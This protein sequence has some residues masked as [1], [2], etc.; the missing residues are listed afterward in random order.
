LGEE[1]VLRANAFLRVG[2]VALGL[3][4]VGTACAG[5]GFEAEADGM[6]ASRDDALWSGSGGYIDHG[7]RVTVCFYEGREAGTPSTEQGALSRDYSIVQNQSNEFGFLAWELFFILQDELGAATGQR[8]VL[9]R[10]CSPTPSNSSDLSIILFFD[11]EGRSV[12]WASHRDRVLINVLD[13]QRYSPE[14]VIVHEVLHAYGFSHEH[15]HSYGLPEDV[16]GTSCKGNVA[17]PA[18]GPKK[19]KF[20]SLY[21]VEYDPYSI[22]NYCKESF[23]RGPTGGL[24]PGGGFDYSRLNHL[25]FWDVAVLRHQASYSGRQPGRPFTYIS[26][27]RGHTTYRFL[28]DEIAEHEVSRQEVRRWPSGVVEAPLSELSVS[29][30]AGADVTID[31]FARDVDAN[32]WLAIVTVTDQSGAQVH[33]QMFLP[34]SAPLPPEYP[35]DSWQ[36]QA[37]MAMEVAVPA[38]LVGDEYTVTFTTVDTDLTVVDETLT[39]SW[40]TPPVTTVTA[41]STERGFDGLTFYLGDVAQ[42]DTDITWGD[43]PSILDPR[44]VPVFG[45]TSCDALYNGEFH[46]ANSWIALSGTRSPGR[47]GRGPRIGL[48]GDFEPMQVGT[49][50]LRI[51][52]YV[53]TTGWIRTVKTIDVRSPVPWGRLSSPALDL[54]I[55]AKA[56]AGF[57]FWHLDPADEPVDFRIVELGVDPASTR[58]AFALQAISTFPNDPP[59]EDFVFNS[60]VGTSDTIQAGFASAPDGASGA[61]FAI[62][63]CTDPDCTDFEEVTSEQSLRD[64]DR[65]AFESLDGHGCL[66]LKNVGPELTWPVLNNWPNLVFD[67]CLRVL[68]RR[69]PAWMDFSALQ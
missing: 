19:S 24:P 1:I 64:G 11:A 12:V 10:D 3:A 34:S 52:H 42:I 17:S 58:T 59:V 20:Y 45:R 31:A 51:F 8:F 49:C 21:N 33:Q 61:R 63:R 44:H 32:L 2:A 40:V 37:E 16:L 56:E 15:R 38:G 13:L 22:M 65:I 54:E 55:T 29:A 47:P 67:D 4:V 39:I 48:S 68:S 46:P 69:G 36:R 7:R 41:S 5:E 66:A 23:L 57:I 50:R 25:S 9:K 30:I 43:G 6:V 60:Y 26:G 53:P 18:S 62:H 28:E 27:M 14:F 35:A